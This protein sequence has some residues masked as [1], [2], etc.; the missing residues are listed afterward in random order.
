MPDTFF[1][2]R[3]N[4]PFSQHY[5]TR[6]LSFMQQLMRSLAVHIKK[7]HFTGV[8]AGY[9]FFGTR[10]LSIFTT[11]SYANTV[12]H[13]TTNAVFGGPHKKA[14]FYRCGCRIRFSGMRKLAIFTTF[15]STMSTYGSSPMARFS[16]VLGGKCRH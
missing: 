6:T 5:L 14:S 3:E 11:L 4:C 8:D 15:S 9:V 7:L 12:V 2:E 13:A 1:S 10:K 16:T